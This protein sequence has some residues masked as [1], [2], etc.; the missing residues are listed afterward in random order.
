MFLWVDGEKQ[1]Q[2][3]FT[4]PLSLD[5]YF[6]GSKKEI[7]CKDTYKESQKRISVRIVW[8]FLYQK[9]EYW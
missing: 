3:Y 1:G 5:S 4:L 6:A 9:N 2:G 8:N 7:K